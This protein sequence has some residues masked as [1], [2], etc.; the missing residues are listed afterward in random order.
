M[1]IMGGVPCV[2]CHSHV[3]TRAG[4]RPGLHE[5]GTT[6]SLVSWARVCDRIGAGRN[7]RARARSVAKW[8]HMTTILI[9]DDH[10]VVRRGLKML[11]ES[12]APWRVVAEA[13][14][15]KGA[16]DDAFR[17]KPDVAIIDYGLPHLNGIEAARQIRHHLPRTEIL[18]FT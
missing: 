18:I 9:A 3:E 1:Q 12:R 8:P 4:P 10:D 13:S 15:G 14:D 11:L 16:V 17:L 6:H 7:W 5:A 2:P